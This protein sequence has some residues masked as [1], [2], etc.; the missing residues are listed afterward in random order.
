[1]IR[2]NFRWTSWKI[3]SY[4]SMECYLFSIQTSSLR[5]PAHWSWYYLSHSLWSSI[6][7]I[8]KPSAVNI[9]AATKLLVNT[10]DQLTTMPCFNRYSSGF[11]DMDAPTAL[12]VQCDRRK[13]FIKTAV[14]R[15]TYVQKQDTMMLYK[16]DCSK[17]KEELWCARSYG[18]LVSISNGKWTHGWWNRSKYLQISVRT[19]MAVK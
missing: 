9:V 14:P 5:Y 7:Y 10:W 1:M 11:S 19:I 17:D 13:W 12:K 4:E 3:I 2:L 8:H 15:H 18:T 6:Y 16:S